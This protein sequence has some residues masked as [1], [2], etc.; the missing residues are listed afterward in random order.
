MTEASSRGELPAEGGARRLVVGYDGSPPAH[1][2]ARA[3][4]GLAQPDVGRIWFVHAT[5]P[6]RRRTEPITEEEIR[7]HARAAIRAMES[8]VADCGA[9]GLVAEAVSREGPAAEVLLRVA[10]EVGADLIV[11]GTRGRGDAGRVLLGSVSLRV[12]SDSRLPTVVVP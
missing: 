9:R 5:Q 2:A 12:L 10:S 6:D 8:L 7:S 3:A 1:R 11:V 4:I